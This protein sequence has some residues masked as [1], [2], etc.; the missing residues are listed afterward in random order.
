MAVIAVFAVA[1]TA[2]C[3]QHSH[4]ILNCEGVLTSSTVLHWPHFDDWDG[5]SHEGKPPDIPH[6]N[7]PVKI[8]PE[9]IRITTTTTAASPDTASSVAPATTT[10]A[11]NTDSVSP[12]TTAAEPP[13]STTT[14]SVPPLQQE[15]VTAD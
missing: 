9:G 3:T 14:S 12:E 2:A 5:A 11:P 13:P 8:E 15:P 1:A 10:T 6:P 4:R 7:C